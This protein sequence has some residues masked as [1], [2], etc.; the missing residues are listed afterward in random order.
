[1]SGSPTVAE[2][3]QTSPA[4]DATRL[5]GI[6]MLALSTFVF[7]FS[8]V[9]A[10]WST[11]GFPVGESLFI[12]AAVSLVL[13][14]PVLRLDELVVAVRLNPALHT[15]R[16]V[17]ASV[18]LFCFYRAVTYLQLADVTT[19][20]LATPIML[21]AISAVLLRETVG[22]V[23]WLATLAGF[24]GVLIALR[25]S[26][27]AVSWAAL[28][29]LSGS[30]IYTGVLA[31][32]RRLRRT[33]NM[34]LVA[35]QLGALLLLSGASLPFAWTPLTLGAAAMLGLV[36]AISVLGYVCVNRAL[37]LAP[38]SAVAPFQYASIIWS[39]LLGYLVFADVPDP[40][41]MTGAA[42]IMS[43]GLFILLRERLASVRRR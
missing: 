9:L 26:S 23:R 29:A 11:A 33:P 37:Q 36:G 15:L 39:V 8:N 35:T 18:E 42:I 13:I 3:Q 20:Y 34:V 10:K 25:P 6:G 5:A 32:T 41:T 28:Y 19:F 7:S 43:A 22:W 30:T 12:R 14:A 24:A 27:H 16:A 1:V 21:T 31:I 4:E 40:A 2:Q 38:A 17:G